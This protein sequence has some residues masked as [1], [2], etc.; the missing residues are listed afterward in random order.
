MDASTCQ[1]M[2]TATDLA[3]TQLLDL[4]AATPTP[5]LDRQ[6]ALML[7]CATRLGA[8]ATAHGEAPTEAVRTADT[9]PPPFYRSLAG[10][11]GKSGGDRKS[12]R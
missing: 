12:T 6:R 8:A 2:V 4:I 7:R 11:G 3:C 1:S 10:L 5:L 9:E